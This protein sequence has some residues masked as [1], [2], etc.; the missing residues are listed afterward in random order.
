MQPQACRCGLPMLWGGNMGRFMK[1][2]QE[3]RSMPVSGLE[4]MKEIMERTA[5]HPS[6]RKWQDVMEQSGAVTALR[7]LQKTHE[8]T[9]VSEI[10]KK[11][12]EL[13]R[14]VPNPNA[15]ILRGDWLAERE[16]ERQA[17][18]RKPLDLLYG[19][20]IDIWEKIKA[21]DKERMRE[22]I[23]LA[24]SRI[25][26]NLDLWQ[27]DF[28]SIPPWLER[29]QSNIVRPPLPEEESSAEVIDC[30]VV[31]V[32]PP[33]PLGSD[34]V[35]LI[36]EDDEEGLKR[37]LARI[38]ARKSAKVFDARTVALYEDFIASGLS[39]TEFAKRNH[40]KHHIGYTT[41][42]KKLQ[43]IEEKVEGIKKK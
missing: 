24:R 8:N 2:E 35:R 19:R 20:P 36:R 7:N 12:Q 43:G 26:G 10:L 16:A 22:V 27:R 32:I 23:E 37:A 31:P 39:K 29:R 3:P 38:N 15:L 34:A 11:H 41:C 9:L 21:E 4:R 6:I 13:S 17:S 5:A 33:V 28:G 42:R 18:I 30:A 25:R 1:T 14:F 40:K